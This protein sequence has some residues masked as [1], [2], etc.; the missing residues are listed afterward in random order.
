MEVHSTSLSFF[1]NQCKYIR[2]SLKKTKKYG[3]KEI[4]TLFSTTGS[5]SFRDGVPK[6]DVEHFNIF[7]LQGQILHLLQQIISVYASTV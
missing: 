6:V 5:L 2:Y 7:I 4:S 1:Q 3:A